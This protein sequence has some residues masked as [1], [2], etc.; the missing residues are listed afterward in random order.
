MCKLGNGN[1]T[2]LQFWHLNTLLK[3]R[4]DE[5]SYSEESGNLLSLS[6]GELGSLLSERDAHPL[7]EGGQEGVVLASCDLAEEEELV[8]GLVAENKNVHDCGVVFGS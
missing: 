8:R 1:Q 3:V 6:T 7:E 2:A 5:L 4:F